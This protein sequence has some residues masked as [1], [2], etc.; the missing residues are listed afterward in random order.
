MSEVGQIRRANPRALVY[1][2]GEIEH[3]DLWLLDLDTGAERPLT[4][5]PS[6]FNICD[7]D[8]SPDGSDVTLERVQERSDVVMLDLS[9]P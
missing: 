5:L 6:D 8:I 2:R 1:L 4:K 9:R 7:F 3:K